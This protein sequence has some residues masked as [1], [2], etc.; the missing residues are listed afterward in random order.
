MVLQMAD[1][2]KRRKNLIVF[3]VGFKPELIDLEL[4][5]EPIIQTQ[6]AK[7]LGILFDRRLSFKDHM[8]DLMAKVY[9]RLSLLKLLKGTNCGSRP[10]TILKAYKCSIRPI[11]EYGALI[12]GGLRESQVKKCRSFKISV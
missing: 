9:R 10:Y 3:S 4:F 1:E 8:K 11:F 12:A 6:T 2:T 7:L 5:S